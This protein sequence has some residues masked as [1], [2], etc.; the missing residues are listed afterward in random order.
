MFDEKNMKKF[1][2]KLSFY[3]LEYLTE[4][5]VGEKEI[6]SD[7]VYNLVEKLTG[8]AAPTKKTKFD[9]I[10][11]SFYLPVRRSGRR[12]SIP[13]SVMK[14]K[15]EFYISFRF[16]G[17]LKIS[18]GNDE[19]EKEYKE[20]FEDALRFSSL[21]RDTNGEIA[22]K[23]VPYDYRTG[24]IKGKYVMDKLMPGKEKTRMLKLYEKH[25]EKKLK[26]SG[27]SLDDYLDTAAVCYRAAYP[28]K[29]KG[30]SSLEMYKKWADG[31]HGGMLDIKDFNSRDE[32]M[33]WK[34]S[35]EWIGAHPY[36]IVFSWHRHGIHLYPP[37][38]DYGKPYYVLGVTNYAYA[39]DFIKMAKAL[40]KEEIPF[41]ANDF[42]DVLNFLAGEKYFTVND[43][44]ELRFL[45]IPSREYKNKYFKYIEWDELK[46]VDFD[47]K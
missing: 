23:T 17:N 24:K 5:R 9:T 27:V 38:E 39:G 8:I 29:A 16:T 28:K 3:E 10:W 34:K 36:E 35:S 12:V 41:H 46:V 7:S 47:F 25:R 26:T 13:F 30:L 21:I 42:D 32:F 1:K 43:Y 40:I 18:R 37:D 6:K 14:Y 20:I 15:D 31:R 44:D 33:G 11:E 22:V 45:Y 2:P 19:I 4:T